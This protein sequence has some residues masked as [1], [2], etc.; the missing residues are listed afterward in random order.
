MSYQHTR[1]NLILLLEAYHWHKSKREEVSGWNPEELHKKSFQ[2]QIICFNF[3][4]KI[5]GHKGKG[6]ICGLHDVLQYLILIYWE[7][8]RRLKS[9]GNILFFVASTRLFKSKGKCCFG[10]VPLLLDSLRHSSNKNLLTLFIGANTKTSNGWHICFEFGGKVK[11]LMFFSFHFWITLRLKCDPRLR[12]I[13]A[14]SPSSLSCGRRTSKN[15][16]AKVC[17]S[18]QPL[19]VTSNVPGGGVPFI[20]A[21]YRFFVL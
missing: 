5:F 10:R 2:N 1:A 17:S 18:N 21:G 6:S 19:F 20:L 4:P 9:T 12:A 16:L 7:K 13:T 14:N 8:S 3:L 11:N 15:H